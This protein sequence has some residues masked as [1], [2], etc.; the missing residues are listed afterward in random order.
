MNRKL[1]GNQYIEKTWRTF[2]LVLS[3][4]WIGIKEMDRNPGKVMLAVLMLGLAF[5][6]LIHT[7]TRTGFGSPQLTQTS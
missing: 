3:G 2:K 1:Y 4:T 5:A 6:T 7:S